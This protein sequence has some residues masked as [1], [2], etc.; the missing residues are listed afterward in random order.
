MINLRSTEWTTLINIQYGACFGVM[1]SLLIAVDS[2]TK[3]GDVK[4]LIHPSAYLI[5]PML[6]VYFFADW[7]GTNLRRSF[8]DTTVPQLVLICVWVWFLGFVFLISKGSSDD[9]LLFAGLYM[10]SVGIYHFSLYHFGHYYTK[11]FN[12]VLGYI[13]S[14]IIIVVGLLLMLSGAIAL[15]AIRAIDDNFLAI[16]LSLSLAMKLFELYSFLSGQRK[17]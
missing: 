12:S 1:F 8:I 5:A 10:T 17:H 2:V 3:I 11:D 9:K 16:L 4:I 13:F 7:I 15:N 6:L 14:G